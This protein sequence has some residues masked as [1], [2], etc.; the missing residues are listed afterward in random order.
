MNI[1]AFPKQTKTIVLNHRL[2]GTKEEYWTLRLLLDG[3]IANVH[4]SKSKAYLLNIAERWT[5]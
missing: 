5:K 1:A 4:T 2:A 3:E